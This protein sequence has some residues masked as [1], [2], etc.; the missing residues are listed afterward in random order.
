M[1]GWVMEGYS[2]R[3]RSWNTNSEGARDYED[4]AL[5]VV[6]NLSS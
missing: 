5:V 6:Y 2:G 1:N 4:T 3:G